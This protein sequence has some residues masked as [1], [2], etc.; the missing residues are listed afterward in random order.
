V[1]YVKSV[2]S[3]GADFAVGGL[4]RSDKETHYAVKF[5]EPRQNRGGNVWQPLRSFRKHLF[6]GIRAEDLKIDGVWVP[7]TEDWAFMLP[8][9]EL[10]K[11]PAYLTRVIYLYE[12]SSLKQTLSKDEREDLIA[13]I[14][15]KP[16]YRGARR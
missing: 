1:S 16:S 9:A 12:P 13:K 15:S 4:L 10:A 2:F 3:E 14:V 6:D 11:H 7:H 5:R 8:M